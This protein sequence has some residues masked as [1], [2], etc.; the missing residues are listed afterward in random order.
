MGRDVAKCGLCVFL[1]L[2][3]S[4]NWAEL[5]RVFF[6]YWRFDMDTFG[7]VVDTAWLVVGAAMDFLGVCLWTMLATIAVSGG[8]TCGPG[9]WAA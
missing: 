8:R 5:R 2:R 6:L 1:Y 7:C 3:E 4:G 9:K